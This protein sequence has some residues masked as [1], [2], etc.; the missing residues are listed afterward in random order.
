MRLVVVLLSLAPLAHA[1]V[2]INE[3]MYNPASSNGGNEWI[4]LYNNEGS[5]IDI[6]GW[7]IDRAKSSTSTWN[8]RYTIPSSTTIASGEFLV[9]GG[10]TV[11]FADLNLSGSTL[12]FG[13]SNDAVRLA[14]DSATVVD[15]VVYGSDNADGW[16]DDNG[17]TASPA[18]PASEGSSIA[19]T[20]DGS[21][22]NDSSVD[23]AAGT[24]TPGA[25]NVATLDCDL[26]DAVVINEFFPN[27]ASGDDGFEWIEL[28]SDASA[29]L[30]LSGWRLATG[31]SSF[32]EIAPIPDGTTIAPGEFLVVAQ[33]DQVA[34]YDVIAAGFDLHN[35]S[36]GSADGVR[37]EDC[38][39]TVADTVIY[40]A[41]NTG[42][43]WLDDTGSVA[44]SLAPGQSEGQ[45]VARIEDGVDTDLSGDDFQLLPF[46]TPGLA[47]D[48]APPDCGGP[49]SGIVVNEALPNPLGD[50]EGFEWVELYHSGTEAIDLTDW[51]LSAYG[52]TWS[53]LVTFEEGT[54][55]APGEY[56]LLGGAAIFPD[57]P[58]SGSLPN[59]TNGDGIRLAD[60]SGAVADTL[61]YGPP[62]NDL[63]VDDTGATAVNLA[64]KPGD[65]QV[66][67]RLEDGYDTDDCKH[68]FGAHSDATPGSANPVIPPVECVPSAGGVVLNEVLVNQDGSDDGTG[69]WVELFNSTG[70]DVRLDGWWV[71]GA[72]N[73]DNLLTAVFV[74]PGQTT[75][76]AGGFLVVGGEFVDEADVVASFTL[77][78]GTNGDA[79]RLNDC[80]DTAVDTVVFGS[81]NDALLPDDSGA[82][83]VETSETPGSDESQARVPDG[84]D[85]DAAADWHV[86]SLPTPG[87]TN[88]HEGGDGG[89]TDPTGGC[90]SRNGPEGGEPGGC[91]GGPP[92][93]TGDGEAAGCVTVPGPFGA[94][95]VLAV[96]VAWRRRRS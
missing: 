61:V 69:E 90:G 93:M 23:F 89:V 63:V 32:G 65:D 22:T 84:V 56:L 47:N 77:P 36:S 44:T 29:T 68:D 39:G 20:L 1:G 9:I 7:T 3:V 73:P 75:I 67:A 87:A 15:T 21:D 66:L 49:G 62:N 41:D 27:P 55:I 96:L 18:A 45:S 80:E 71:A 5:A 72:T 83:A 31:T 6:S 46:P 8:T 43:A 34:I 12:D 76:P 52:S 82:V 11:G 17:S 13:N 86:D 24:A 50:D 48:S 51:T 14:D 16:L 60:C 74:L 38:A 79:I 35:N 30:D 40:G 58:F 25:T 94:V 42:D 26:V 88:V 10:E 85:T 4:E 78:N 2:T 70:A 28:Y 59:G 95:W 33:S 19:R 54:S 57:V 53:K 64:P 92:A 81:N 91:G 37:L